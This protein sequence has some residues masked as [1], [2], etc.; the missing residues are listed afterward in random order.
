[1]TAIGQQEE[2]AK[3]QNGDKTQDKYFTHN[4]YSDDRK[5]NRQ[6][7]LEIIGEIRQSQRKDN[8]L[9]TIVATIRE[10]TQADRVFVYRFQDEERG[11]VV[12]ESRVAGWTPSLGEN[13]P[14]IAFGLEYQRQYLMRVAVT[15]DSANGKEE[16]NAPQLTPYQAQLLDR[17]QV[18]SS[19]SLPI[20]VEGEVWGLLVIHQCAMGRRWQEE[21]IDLLAG[22]CLELTA[23]LQRDRFAE[24]IQEQAQ[25]DD[26]VAKVIA[27]I[28]QSL[29][30][31]TIFATTTREV[32]L[33]LKCDR[34]AVYRFNPDW[35]GDFIAESVASG[36]VTIMGSPIGSTTTQNLTRWADPYFEETQGGRFRKN[37]AFILNDISNNDFTPCHIEAL[38]QYEAKACA[39]VSIFQ[40]ETLWGLLAVY[41]NDKPRE[42]QTVEIEFLKQIA[43]QFSVALQ[44]A[45][46]LQQAQAKSAR[47]AQLVEQQQAVARVISRIRQSLE[48]NTIFSTTTKEARLLLGC[49]RV[50]VFRFNADWGGEFIA[51]S[52]ASGW[53]SL[54]DRQQQTPQLRNMVTDCGSLKTLMASGSDN[55]PSRA[56]WTDTYL[57]NAQGESLRRKDAF[58]TEDIYQ[59]GFSPCYLEILEQN[60]ARAYAIVPLFSGNTLWGM[61][62]AYQNSGA[63]AWQEMEIDFLKQIAAQ[64]NIVLQ[65]SEYVSQI[66]NQSQALAKAADREKNFV[67]FL[68]KINQKIVEQSQK[69]L[70]LENLLRTSNH[71]LRKLLRVDRVVI[72][73]FN[74][75]WSRKI[76]CEDRNTRLN[77][78]LEKEVK[79]IED[80]DIQESQGGRYRNRE[81]L[82]VEDLNNAELSSFETE[83]FEQI[84]AKACAIVPIFEGEQLWGLL[85]TYQSD[86]TRA[87]EE[88][89]INLLVQAGV[90]LGVAIQQADYLARVLSQSQ[91]ITLAANREKAS[92]EQLQQRASH[93]LVAVM[94][95][96]SGDLTVRAPITDDEIGTIADAYNGTLQSL[97]KIVLQ[98]Q[99]AS[100]Q[101]AMTAQGNTPVVEGFVMQ[102]Q[103][104]FRDLKQALDKVQQMLN[105]TRTAAE[106]AKRVEKALQQANQTLHKGDE[107]MNLTVGSIL[108]IRETVTETA[109]RIRRLSES[110]QKISRVVQSIGNFATQ[111]NLLAM[112][113]ALEATRAGEYGRG[114]AVVAEEVRSLSVQSATA[115]SEIEE[116][117]ATIQS[118][119]A[120]VAKAAELGLEQVLEGTGLVDEVRASL[121]EIAAATEQIS[122][123]VEGIIQVTQSQQKQAGAVTGAIENIGA[124]ANN[125]S[126]KS[127]QISESFR[128]LLS[129][130]RDL[131]KSVGQ[132]KVR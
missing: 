41:Q 93:L 66:Q 26:L 31:D 77:G 104:Q 85:E 54:I 38:E 55:Q 20:L 91:Q 46:I 18:R 116:L 12:A 130:A 32:R 51:E 39:I 131:H 63:R 2:L 58:V 122:Q 125:T 87:W 120:E 81:N 6:I 57:Q 95:A 42:W 17:L 75:D 35:S 23:K 89:E 50:A 44:Q 98:V 10:N 97:R 13:L 30:L 33:L 64:F 94:P 105:L 74:A 123:Q 27:R 48:L 21:E 14:A 129:L 90:Q 28:R 78:Q 73:K 47:L 62:A 84:D 88:G 52:V 16:K 8:W 24:Q 128:I 112:N 59:A 49:D 115:T 19:L 11:K 53:S 109:E 7:S 34:V 111:T 76:I 67:R 113:A 83:W 70:T 132:F 124:I 45:Q 29:E 126:E 25:R 100:R 5:L 61:L 36:W 117:V 65:Q 71:E 9:E 56:Q 127:K 99:N 108:T 79:L 82:I 22:I 92:K 118:E 121:N 110:S 43:A 72:S 86:R 68:V 103:N 119:T 102:M 106:R 1:M 114:F 40:G 37:E 80:P 96:L 3:S 101:V 4:S 15:L 60:E 107:T 69:K